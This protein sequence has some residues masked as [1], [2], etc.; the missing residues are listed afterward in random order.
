MSDEA[1]SSESEEEEV[2]YPPWLEQVVKGDYY[3]HVK[4]FKEE[5]KWTF[6]RHEGLDTPQ[7]CTCLSA[8]SKGRQALPHSP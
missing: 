3:D 2:K 4:V 1:M 8:A 6:R 5:G 7:Q